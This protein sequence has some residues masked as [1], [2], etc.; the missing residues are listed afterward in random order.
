MN[1]NPSLVLPAEII[2]TGREPGRLVIGLLVPLSGIMGVIGPSSVN[3]ARL[4]A[5]EASALGDGRLVDVV[6]I[7]A[8]RSGADVASEIAALVS[9]GL[10]DGVVGCHTSDIRAAVTHA[11]RGRV[12]YIFTPPREFDR[13]RNDGSYFLGPAPDKQL[14]GPLRWMNEKLRIDRWSLIGSDYVWPRHVHRAARTILG[15]LGL[16]VASERT[17]RFGEVDA[18]MIL[19]EARNAHAQ[20][21][22]V[23]LVGSDAVEFH[24]QFGELS[25]T[26]GMPRL[27]TSLDEDSLL[28]IGGDS[29]GNLLAA[30]PSFLSDDDERHLELLAAYDSRFGEFAPSL[31][32]YSE[33]VY[34][35]THLMAALQMTGTGIGSSL[36]RAASEMLRGHEASWSSAPLG[37]PHPT[38]SLAQANGVDMDVVTR[39]ALA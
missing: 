12:P 37:P 18:D 19:R 29:T 21:L 5:E 20:G 17:V 2:L 28:A 33:S 32:T 16:D 13:N 8:G 36:Q 7:D 25:G 23:S 38:M 14:A 3:C 34:D 11:I 35:G 30:M 27:C 6:L 26:H 31:G 15:S 1:A 39:F 24:R 9:S 10:I 4:A 22:I